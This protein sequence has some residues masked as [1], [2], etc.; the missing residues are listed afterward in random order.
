M[1][2]TA[3]G[4][5]TANWPR[6]CAIDAA[7]CT[8][9]AGNGM[10]AGHLLG[11]FSINHGTGTQRYWHDNGRLQMEIDSLNGGS[12]DAPG[13][14]FETARWFGETFLIG[15]KNVTRAAYLKAARKHPD[16]PQY[17]GQPAGRVARKS[18]ALECKQHKLF[19]ES[20]LEKAHAEA[21]RW[22]S[23]GKRPDLRSL[24]K[25]RTARA[26]LH[27][28][29]TLYDAGADTVIAVPIYPRQAGKI[30]RRLVAGQTAGGIIQT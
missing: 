18:V 12:T 11:S 30:I 4:I 17:K 22:L 8:A 21:G 2:F 27:F 10:K 1:D 24:A 9:P 13:F 15:D 3:P 7:C 16:W 28:V 23:A 26:A 20:I 14:G 5:S 6:N 19:I 25:F 29:E